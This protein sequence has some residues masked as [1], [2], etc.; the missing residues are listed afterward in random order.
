M[1]SSTANKDARDLL[2][3][4]QT[5]EY[6]RAKEPKDPNEK[7]KRRCEKEREKIVHQSVGIAQ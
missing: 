7:E 5:V 4:E 2:F 3:D 1:S 6:I